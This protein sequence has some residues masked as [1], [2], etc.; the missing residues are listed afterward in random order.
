[1]SIYADSIILNANVITM[2]PATPSATAVAVK[3]GRFLAV[4]HNGDVSEF[5][6][7]VT[8]VMDANG[9]TVLPGFIDAHTHVMSSGV[10][11]VAQEDC[12]LRSIGEIQE[13]LKGPL[14]RYPR[15]Q[16]GTWI[17]VRRHQDFR[18]ALP[19]PPRPRRRH[20]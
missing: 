10:R 6:G 18:A 5:E 16:L 9:K 12:D 7:N 20:H 14:R 1:M 8:E 4:G 15:G 3:D 11:H 2:N 19:P 13:G 17:Q